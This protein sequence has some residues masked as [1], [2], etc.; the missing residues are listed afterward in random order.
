[1]KL[2]IF[3]GSFAAIALGGCGEAPH[4]DPGARVPDT[5]VQRPLPNMGRFSGRDA[6][7]YNLTGVIGIH[8]Q[9]D[10]ALLRVAA[11]S[12]QGHDLPPVLGLSAQPPSSAAGHQVYIIG[13]P[14]LDSRNNLGVMQRIFNNIYNVKRLQP[15]EITAILD[16]KNWFL[17]DCST[18]GGNSGSCVIDLETNLVIGLHFGGAYLKE[19]TAI[20]LWRL[21]DDPLIQKANIRYI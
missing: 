10:L 2:K 21:Q 7:E 9:Y 4:D 13:Y 6:L 18:L 3:L 17:H 11:H 5:T 14:A 12:R 15:G 19:N 1:M 8:E 16:E 20:S